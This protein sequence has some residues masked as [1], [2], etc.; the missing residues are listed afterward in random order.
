MARSGAGAVLVTLAEVARVSQV[1]E[2]GDDPGFVEAVEAFRR[3]L[4]AQA[5]ARGLNGWDELAQLLALEQALVADRSLDVGLAAACATVRD[6]VAFR[7]GELAA[8][9]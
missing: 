1:A 9:N 6:Y 4:A 5:A 3:V 2:S 8:L 7:R